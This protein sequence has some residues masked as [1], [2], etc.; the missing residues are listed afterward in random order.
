MA[1]SQEQMIPQLIPGAQ[2]TVIMGGGFIDK[3]QKCFEYHVKDHEAEL[4]GLRKRTP[5]DYKNN[6]FTPWEETAVFFSTLMQEVM[7]KAKE[8]GQI[9][10]VPMKDFILQRI[11]KEG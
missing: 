2:V 10:E 11:P 3:I 4:E 1:E 8:Q 5:E 9:E 6:N 7:L